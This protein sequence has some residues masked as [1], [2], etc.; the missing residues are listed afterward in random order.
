MELS[1]KDIALLAQEAVQKDLCSFA[2]RH[3]VLG[4]VLS[5][6][7]D[8]HVGAT[9]SGALSER[10]LR[11]LHTLRQRAILWELERDRLLLHLSCCSL[12]SVVL[13]GAALQHTAYS[14]PVQRQMGDL[15]LL[16]PRE[17]IEDAVQALRSLGYSNPWPDGAIESYLRHHFHIRL[18]HPKGSIVELHWDLI[19]P[20]EPFQLDAAA[21]LHRSRVNHR[22]MGPDFRVPSP[23]DMVLHMAS[24]NLGDS[25]RLR[26][27]VDVDRTIAC[28]ARLDWGYLER[29]AKAGRL[30][31]V[32][33]LSLRLCETLLGTSVPPGFIRTL[34]VP[35]IVRVHLTLL[36]P[37]QWVALQP[38]DR[39]AASELRHFWFILGWRPRLK[40]I[41]QM[42]ARREDP[43]NWIWKGRDAPE[44]RAAAPL[45]GI[46]SLFKLVVY[47]AWVY[48]LAVAASVSTSGRRTLRFWG[49]GG[50]IKTP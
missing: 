4:L 16:L 17:H 45:Q 19:R 41:A 48:C 1:E 24:Q 34:R 50:G 11:P 36:R 3:G 10:L 32:L 27:L 44:E 21:F 26:R 14:E 46:A 38:P 6:L 37:L 20:D 30:Q 8:S 40:R 9:L 23:E 42:L 22:S 29:S 5:A 33:A 25:F 35:R 2:I 31:V 47:Q 28:S 13:K 39:T 7:E 12:S 49:T 18:V 43:L 15:D